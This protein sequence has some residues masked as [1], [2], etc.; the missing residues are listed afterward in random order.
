MRNRD[1]SEPVGS[2]GQIHCRAAVESAIGFFRERIGE[3]V[4]VK[5][6]WDR[7]GGQTIPLIG[8]L[9]ATW[10]AKNIFGRLGDFRFSASGARSLPVDQAGFMYRIDGEDV[11]ID[12]DPLTIKG[13]AKSPI[14]DAVSAGQG[15]VGVDPISICWSVFSVLSLVWQVMHPKCDLQIGGSVEAEAVLVG[16]KILV[17]FREMPSV[18]LTVIFEVMLA[19]TG[20]EISTEKVKMLLHGEGMIAGRIKSRELEVV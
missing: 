15:P 5:A 11:V 20:L 12:P 13:L 8:S 16:D 19:V 4:S 2:V 6:I 14:G 17:S 9:P 18:R 3:G 10:T 1:Q 7:T